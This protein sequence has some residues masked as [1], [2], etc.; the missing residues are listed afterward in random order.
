MRVELISSHEG[1]DVVLEC[2]SKTLSEI[3][4]Y[5]TVKLMSENIELPVERLEA[6]EDRLGVSIEGL[7]AYIQSNQFIKI[8]GELHCREGNELNQDIQLV[9][10]AHNAS[11]S[12]L[13][14]TTTTIRANSFFG[15]EIFSQSI[16]P[17]AGDVSKIRIYPK[18]T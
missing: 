13:N 14:A 4:L 17:C 2:R 7:F 10:S 11:G 1:L 15:L 3:N 16:S 9:L 5:K 6:F 12:V 18:T 8:N